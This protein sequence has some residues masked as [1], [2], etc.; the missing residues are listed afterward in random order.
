MIFRMIS[1]LAVPLL[2]LPVLSGC[3]GSMSG[4][5]GSDQLSC[6]VS[7]GV[8]CKPMTEVYEDYGKPA[9]RAAAARTT[10]SV[11]A[12]ATSAEGIVSLPSRGVVYVP[13]GAESGPM[14]LRT[15]PNVMRVW[16]APWVDA[17]G[18]LHEGA[19]IAMQLDDGRWNIDHVRAEI[20][21]TYGASLVPPPV[22]QAA[23]PAAAKPTSVAKD[24]AEVLPKNLL[25]G[26][27]SAKAA[28]DPFFDN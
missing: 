1:R 12:E 21:D 3:A 26:N 10:E 4:L 7:Q 11:S 19:W 18:D 23:K 16:V 20:R 28:D 5:S 6:P 24:V 25:P 22:N 8:T 27:A 14:P 13:P 15:R 2:L 17:D 9:S